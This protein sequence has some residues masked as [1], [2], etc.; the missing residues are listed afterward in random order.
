MWTTSEFDGYYFDPT[1][2]RAVLDLPYGMIGS[3]TEVCCLG[4]RASYPMS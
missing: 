3:S 2:T 4:K 1:D